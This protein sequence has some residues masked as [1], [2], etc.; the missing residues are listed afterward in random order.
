MK[1]ETHEQDSRKGK[2][3]QVWDKYSVILYLIYFIKLFLLGKFY[4]YTTLFQ[5]Q[6]LYTEHLFVVKG[7]I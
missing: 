7:K 4:L 3:R 1:G 2:V 6:Q 5:K